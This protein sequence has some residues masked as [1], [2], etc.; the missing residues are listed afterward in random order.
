MPTKEM[1]TNEDAFK[2]TVNPSES[3]ISP[4]CFSCSKSETIPKRRKKRVYAW[5]RPSDKPKRPACAYNLFYSLERENMLNGN[6]KNPI[7]TAADASR[8]AE[9]QLYDKPKRKHVKTHGKLDFKTPSKW[10]ALDPIYR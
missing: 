10:K 7:Y 1:E 3:R 8:A 2:A 6:D 9:A 4:S 5:K